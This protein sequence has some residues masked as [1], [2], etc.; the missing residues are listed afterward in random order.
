MIVVINIGYQYKISGVERKLKICC[1]SGTYL[2]IKIKTTD[3]P[4]FCGGL[5]CPP[6]DLFCSRGIYRFCFLIIFALLPRLLL[7]L[8]VKIIS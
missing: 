7:T 1:K 3:I 2:D 4:F 5:C 8:K 6:G